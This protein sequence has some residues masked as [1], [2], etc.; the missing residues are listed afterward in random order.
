MKNF[1]IT[2]SLWSC[3]IT[4]QITVLDEG[5]HVLIFGGHH[6]HIGAVSKADFKGNLTTAQ[7]PG[8]KDGV[9]SERW[10]SALSEIG[11]RPVVVVAGIHFDNLDHTG[12]QKVLELTE[13]MLKE[14]ISLL[15][16]PEHF[17]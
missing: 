12:I 9:V 13:S 7:F 15:T 5:I 16:S 1:V 6:T 11:F 17:D 4:A 3:D 2:R 14:L 8:H 10:A